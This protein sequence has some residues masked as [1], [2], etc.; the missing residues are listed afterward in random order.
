MACGESCA[1]EVAPKAGGDLLEVPRPPAGG[2]GGVLPVVTLRHGQPIA[3]ATRLALVQ[4]T[5]TA[6][7]PLEVG[8]CSAGD[9]DIVVFAFSLISTIQI[10]VEIGNDG[11]NW[12]TAFSTLFKRAGF[13]RFKYRGIGSRF[14]RLRYGSAGDPA[15][16]AILTTTVCGSHA[17]HQRGA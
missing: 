2:A 1:S 12:S 11:E 9:V 16:I 13:A 10:D 14:L 3:V 4:G 15:G 8:D 7:E 5:V 17:M 6:S